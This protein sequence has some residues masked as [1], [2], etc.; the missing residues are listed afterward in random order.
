MNNSVKIIGGQWRGRK[1]P[2]P[3]I[4]GVR[5]TP[6]RVREMLFNWLQQDIMGSRCLDLYSGSGALGM[7]G[8][9]R[10]AKNVV[11]VDS[12]AQVCR[13]LKG[14]IKQVAAVGIKVVQQDIFRYLAGD[15]ELFSLVFLDPPFSKGL[16]M[17]TAHWLED[18]GWLMD[19]AKV[20]IEVEKQLKLDGLPSS[21]VLK[22]HKIIGDV[23][24]HLF[25]RF[26]KGIE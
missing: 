15:A 16:A 4:P 10:G 7:E 25:E 5:P 23:G 1:L 26:E 2:F 3:D 14:N 6:S 13:Q 19:N 12:N 9:S 18:K 24:C 11:L 22:K 20:Y 8:A 17:Q 21:W